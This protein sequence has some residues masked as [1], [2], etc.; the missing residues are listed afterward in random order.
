MR[1]T[2]NRPTANAHRMQIIPETANKPPNAHTVIN[3]LE[4][5]NLDGSTMRFPCYPLD[6]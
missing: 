5:M 1:D 4:T 2:E 6:A 3:T